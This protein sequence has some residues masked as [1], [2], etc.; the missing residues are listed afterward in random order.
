MRLVCVLFTFEN[1]AG[2]MDLPTDL[3]TY[4]RT[5]TPSY[6]D[7]TAH[8]KTGEERRRKRRSHRR[9]EEQESSGISVLGFSPIVSRRLKSNRL[10]C[11]H[12][13]RCASLRYS[14]FFFDSIMAMLTPFSCYLSDYP[15]IL[16]YNRIVASVAACWTLL[17]NTSWS[18]TLR[19]TLS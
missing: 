6:R 16:R 17:G 10:D 14:N 3:R 7:A 19:D 13:C 18:Y 11:Q 4:G 2:Q 8:L 9:N 12:R 15:L 5:D 1:N